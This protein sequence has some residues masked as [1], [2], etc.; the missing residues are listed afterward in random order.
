MIGFQFV[1][2]GFEYAWPLDRTLN[3]VTSFLILKQNREWL[4]GNAQLA[5]RAVMAMIRC[6]WRVW[7]SCEAPRSQRVAVSSLS[8]DTLPGIPP[9]TRTALTAVSE[10][11]TIVVDSIEFHEDIEMTEE[12]NQTI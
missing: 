6:C 2:T 1:S 11:S 12:T 7:C 3:V 4:S 10:L 9:R 8:P 5:L